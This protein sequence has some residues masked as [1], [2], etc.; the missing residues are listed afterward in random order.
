MAAT[1]ATHLDIGWQPLSACYWGDSQGDRW[2]FGG[3]DLSGLVTEVTRTV[4][5][6]VWARA[7]THHQGAGLDKGAL[8][9][10]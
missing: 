1:I 6:M 9:C 7:A 4:N 8:L 3:N 5:D 2:A 10:S